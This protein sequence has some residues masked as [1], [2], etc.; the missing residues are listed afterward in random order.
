[1]LHFSRAEVDIAFVD[2]GIGHPV[3]LIHGFGSDTAKCW[4]STGWIDILRDAGR[5]VIA[6]DL[7]G[8][9]QSGKLYDRS[10]YNAQIIAQDAADLLDY[11]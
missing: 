5:R 6:F 1:M 3:L 10:G 7:R 9:G 11:L 8:H 4:R 2:E